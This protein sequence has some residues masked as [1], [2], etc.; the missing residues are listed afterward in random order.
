MRATTKGAFP[1]RNPAAWAALVVLL[2]A[3]CETTVETSDGRRMPPAPRE[4]PRTPEDAPLNAMA[5]ML[6]P[7][8]LDTNGNLR[9][10][11]IQVE[12]Y[13][14]AR[15]F[16]APLHR[17]GTFEF[18]IYA[19]GRAGS[20]QAPNPDPI[21]AW[22]IPP[23]QAA[24]LRSRSLIGPCYAISLSLLDG[25]GTDSIGEQTVD[26]IA[27]FAPADGSPVVSITGVQ[28]VSMASPV[29]E[30]GR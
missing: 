2:A 1:R 18:A 7:K 6:G 9:P 22:S 16:P 20:P 15:P 5:I 17:E 3:G 24:A 4:G 28:T 8:P 26:L 14:F 11:T 25:G 12:A 29:L 13:L 30:R 19:P 27:R 23:E 10:D 21:R